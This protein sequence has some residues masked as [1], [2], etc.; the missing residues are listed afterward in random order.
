MARTSSDYVHGRSDAE[1]ERLAYQANRLSDLLH[2]GIRYP[3]GSRVLEAACGVGAQTVILARNSP[4]AAF[5]SVDIF[6]ESLARAEE[7]V[8]AAGCTN[9]AFHQA[10]VY[11]LPFAAETFD[12]VFVCFLL[13]HL[14]DPLRALEGLKDVLRPGGTITVI[15][16]DHGSAFF[17]PDSEHARRTIRCLVDLQKGMGGNAF[18]GREL[19]HLLRDAGY[20]DVSVTPRCTYA[21]ASRPE[22]IQ[23]VRNI[24]IAMVEGV[25]DEALARGLVDGETWER[26]IRDL[27]RTTEPGGSF[28]YTFFKGIGVKRSP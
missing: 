26:G 24:F 11:H 2:G 15:E 5:V 23:G 10:D 13:E 25:R 18:I 19:F 4:G 1:A 17:H 12:H 20:T 3:P 27:Y 21:D 22:T 14:P 8:R 28:S 16:G 6:R 7:R 9:V